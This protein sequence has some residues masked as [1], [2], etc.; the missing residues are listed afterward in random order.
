MLK[1]VYFC[2][3]ENDKIQRMQQKSTSQWDLG[4]NTTHPNQT[5]QICIASFDEY[6]ER[7]KN[8]C[9]WTICLTW[10]GSERARQRDLFD[11]M[12][13]DL[14]ITLRTR[15]HVN[16]LSRQHLLPTW[17]KMNAIR[18]YAL[19]MVYRQRRRDNGRGRQDLQVRCLKMTKW[20]AVITL[21]WNAHWRVLYRRLHM[22]LAV[23][24]D[25]EMTIST[26]TVLIRSL[27][28][29]RMRRRSIRLL[30]YC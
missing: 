27:S 21:V 14:A 20:V 11:R 9:V 10:N 23:I 4:Y 30:S 15:N 12:S 2:S 25:I 22:S 17:C 28:A 18:W 3:T 6:H 19:R 24:H 5:N 1:Y 16:F 7:I 26:S 29:E 8:A 13:R